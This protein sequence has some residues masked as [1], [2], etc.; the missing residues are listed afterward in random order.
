MSERPVQFQI[1][2]VYSRQSMKAN[3][4]TLLIRSGMELFS[5]YGYRDVSVEDITRR[6]GLSVGTFYK[7][8]RGKESFYDQILSLIEREGIR[9]VERGVNRLHSPVNQLK[10][11]HRFIVLGV[12]RY[13]ILRGV[14]QADE[15]YLYPGID[16]GGGSIGALRDRI[17]EI[18][19]EIIRDGSR[20]GVFRPGLYHDATAMVLAILDAMIAHL[21]DPHIESLSQDMLVLLQRGLRRVLR[22]R[23]REER[24]DRRVLSDD[25]ELDWLDS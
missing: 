17:E 10:V 21:D 24:H 18:V 1:R 5:R 15:R 13:P 4:R 16:I 14:L 6:C 22:L 12:R 3:R 2:L 19:A 23:R 25:D 7:Y 8:F 9:K 11:V 20:R